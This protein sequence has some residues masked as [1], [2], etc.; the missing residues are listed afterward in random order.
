[1][2]SYALTRVI[3]EPEANP[4]PGR[5]RQHGSLSLDAPKVL[6]L[7]AWL[8]DTWTTSR[9]QSGVRVID[10]VRKAETL[11][12]SAAATLG[13]SSARKTDRQITEPFDLDERFCLHTL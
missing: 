10:G 2:V 12:G 9:S 3:G 8:T 13:R 7:K 5:F 4:A 1:M 6:G 11:E